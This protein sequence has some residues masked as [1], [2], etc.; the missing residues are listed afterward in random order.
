MKKLL[1]T[2]ASLAAVTF[3]NS[4]SQD[5]K[6]SAPYKDITVAYGILSMDDTAHYIRVEK[7]FLDEH[8]SAL[9]M[10]QTP[11]S[12]FYTNLDVTIKSF[13]DDN[14]TSL[15]AAKTLTMVDLNNEGYPKEQPGKQGFFTTPSYAFKFKD[16]L[17][18]FAYYR[19]VITNKTSGRVDSSE[20]FGIVN[21]NGNAGS[22][23]FYIS[24]F[25]NAKLSLNF[26][27]TGP[28]DKY[29]LLGVVPIN[30]KMIEGHIIF[31]YAEKNTSTN[32]QVDKSIDYAFATD[33]KD[34]LK[35][36]ELTSQINAIYGYLR[37]EMG[38]APANIERYMDTCEFYIYCGSKELYQYQEITKS[39]NGGITSDQIKPN[40]TN[41]KGESVLGVIGSRAYRY[42]NN[43]YLDDN[44]IAQLKINQ[45]TAD[46]NI[47][48]RSDH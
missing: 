25:V 28:S 41:M 32:E 33:A 19:L 12:S 4:C 38:T 1:F 47:K 15:I 42:Y 43:A 34:P 44:T 48:G 6:V 23:N 45:I 27:K 10:A 37:D 9:T 17:N 21:N 7:A 8:K 26:S 35:Q 31:H 46:L 29:T 39:Q 40:Y 3:L 36:F 30:G 22:N 2:F 13:N 5:F 18:P 16:N 20:L 11:D 24:S 14:G